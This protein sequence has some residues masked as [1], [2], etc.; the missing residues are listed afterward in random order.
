MHMPRRVAGAL[1]YMRVSR[2]AGTS[3]ST[4][5]FAIMRL[6]TSSLPP[7]G[8]LWTRV[9]RAESRRSCGRGG[10]ALV[11]STGD[12]GGEA[13][14]DSAGEDPAG[15]AAREGMRLALPAA[16]A[17]GRPAAAAGAADA[18]R[19]GEKLAGVRTSPAATFRAAFAGA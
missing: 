2:H 1:P 7:L 19:C 4:V 17:S 13:G 3:H 11:V 15:D 6:L 16:S 12:P 10:G 14:G 8:G 9:V 18:R 5:R